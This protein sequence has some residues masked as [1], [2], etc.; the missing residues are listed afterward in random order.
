MNQ[1]SHRDD[2]DGGLIYSSVQ[3]QTQ[4]R[5][6]VKIKFYWGEQL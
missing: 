3:N 6:S 1:S 4:V 2:C 5:E